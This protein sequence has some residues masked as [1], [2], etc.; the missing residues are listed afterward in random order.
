MSTVAAAEDSVR[1]IKARQEV[2]ML[3]VLNENRPGDSFFPLDRLRDYLTRIRVTW[4]LDCPC[5]KCKRDWRAFGR[6]TPATEYLD[7]IVGPENDEV[8]RSDPRKTAFALLGLLI[9]VDHPLLVTGFLRE[10]IGDY[11]F[12]KRAHT[13]FSTAALRHYCSGWANNER[14]FMGF[15]SNFTRALPQ[16]AIPRL[17]DAMYT[18]YGADTILPFINETMIGKANPETGSIRPEGA[19]GT[20]YSF[21]IY[22]EYQ[23]LPVRPDQ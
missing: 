18:V 13:S 9:Y 6:N 12:D 16:F 21:D 22:E 19:N 7:R 3:V 11:H 23:N 1:C 20:V 17:D 2:Q 5:S 15:V 4:I 8:G 14:E 10:H